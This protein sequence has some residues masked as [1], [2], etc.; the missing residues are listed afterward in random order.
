MKHLHCYINSKRIKNENVG[1]L[2]SVVSGLVT[3]SDDK[4]EVVSAFF[5]STFT[6]KVSLGIC[7]YRQG[8]S[9]SIIGSGREVIRGALGKY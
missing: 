6:Y 5:A 7:A 3:A 4:A 1:L 8:S 2:L 9:K